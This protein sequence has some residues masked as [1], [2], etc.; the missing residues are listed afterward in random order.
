MIADLLRNAGKGIPVGPAFV[1]K[2]EDD[3]FAGWPDRPF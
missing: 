2:N 3:K 1:D